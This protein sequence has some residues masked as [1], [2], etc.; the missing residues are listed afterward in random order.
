LNLAHK[1][2]LVP[3]PE[4]E[5]YF[6][7]A[8]GVSRL[9]YNY[10]LEEWN[11]QYTEGLKPNGRDLLKQ[12]NKIKYEKYPFLKDVHRDC[13]SQPFRNLQQAFVNFFKGL[14]GHPIFKKR[15]EHDSFYLANDTFDLKEN[16]IRMP[17]IGWIKMRQSFRFVGK[18][19][20]ATVSREADRWYVS[21][22]VEIKDENIIK[23]RISN[24]SVGIDLGVKDF[25]VL[26]TGEKIEGPKPF[27]KLQK[28]I[29][30]KQRQ[31]SKK[32]LHSSNWYKCKEELSKLYLRVKNIRKD[33]LHKFSTW[34]CRE[35]QA[36]A[37][38]DLNVVGLVQNHK[39]AKAILDMGWSEFK[40][41]LTYKSKIYNNDLLIVDRFFP[42]SKL[43]SDCGHKLEK[44]DLSQREWICPK[45]GVVHDRDENA[46]INLLNQLGQVM[47]EVTPVDMTNV[48][49]ETGISL[50]TC[51][52][53]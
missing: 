34:L 20:N 24:N 7:K 30:R 32:K 44:L 53:A 8:C 6:R 15:G 12:F 17:K 2:R 3:T 11:K 22:S 52:N 18:I 33:F 43:C 27:K 14:S 26:S 41:Q 36:I 51:N 16:M 38:E 25:A 35:N 21:I 10:A 48:V 40:R 23:E 39:L 29:S 42:S 50:W 19:M 37:I 47:P 5:Q 4:Q 46:A 31:L 28:Q 9:I 49:N 45:C 1:I 13:N